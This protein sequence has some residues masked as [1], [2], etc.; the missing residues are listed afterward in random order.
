[1]LNYLT[2]CYFAI[3]ISVFPSFCILLFSTN[4][5]ITIFIIFDFSVHKSIIFSYVLPDSKKV[6]RKSMPHTTKYSKYRKKAIF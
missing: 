3:A 4:A 1:M 5:E 6:E 2:G